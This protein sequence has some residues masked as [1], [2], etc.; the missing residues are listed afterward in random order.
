MNAT[1]T[2]YASSSPTCPTNCSTVTATCQSNWTWNKTMNVSCTPTPSWS[3]SNPLDSNNVTHATSYDT[4]TYYTVSNNVCETK[5]KYK[6]TWCESGWEPSDDGKKCNEITN[7]PCAA[8]TY[9][10]GSCSYSIPASNHWDIKTVNTSTNGYNWSVTATC[11]NSE[12]SYTSASCTKKATCPARW[13]CPETQAWLECKAYAMA[14]V[15]SP[16]TC[17]QT[18]YTCGSNGT[19]S[20]NPVWSSEL[21]IA[22]TQK[23]C[24][25]YNLSAT[26]PSWDCYNTFSKSD[27]CSSTALTCYEEGCKGTNDTCYYPSAPSYITNNTNYVITPFTH[28]ECATNNCFP[29][30]TKVH[31]AD[32]LYKNIEDVV[33]GDVVL[34]YNEGTKKMEPNRVLSPLVHENVDDE[35]YELVIDW[36]VLKVTAAHRFYA[37]KFVI[38]WYQSSITY[39]WVAAK[40][41]K[42]WDRLFMKDGKYGLVQQISHYAIHGTVYNLSVENNHTYFVEE[43]YLVHNVKPDQNYAWNCD[44]TTSC[45]HNWDN[46]CPSAICNGVSTQQTCSRKVVC[47]KQSEIMGGLWPEC[48]YAVNPDEGMIQVNC[49]SWETTIWDK[50]CQDAYWNVVAPS[51][52]EWKTVPAKC[53]KTQLA[54]PNP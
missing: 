51:N 15:F 36:N 28:W 53:K 11:T 25:D 24:A 45:T 52:C 16:N 38:T 10:H 43:W 26:T 6:V 8:T 1:V 37:A 54:D 2:T 40:D 31:M 12:R 3:C 17:T 50:Y 42:V 29:A 5:Y 30:W 48:A 14:C 32:W 18:T 13:A 9:T 47:K 19:R 33:T 7:K 21:C 4:C 41:L 27:W 49:C 34:S 44:V 35:M 39:S 22:R 20:P 23:T 46:R